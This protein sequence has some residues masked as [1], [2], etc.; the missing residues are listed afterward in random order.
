[1]PKLT[2]YDR[3]FKTLNL[4]E[5]DTVPTFEINIH[6]V[7]R[8]AILSGASYE[9]FIEFMDLDAAVYYEWSYDKYETLN[10]VKKIVRDKFGVVKRYTTEI[11]PIPIESAIKSEED[12]DKYIAPDPD[13]PWKYEPLQKA[14]QR[15]KDQ[16]PVIATVMDVFYQ[17]NEIRGM[18]DHFM[19]IIRKPDLIERLN[20]IVLNYNLR[21]IRNC[22]EVGVDII[23]ITGDLATSTGPMVSP[24]HMQRFAIPA[25][26]SMVAE[27]KKHGVPCLR[28]THGNIWTIFDMI[29]D[30][31]IDA[32]HPI[33]PEAGM[34]I[35]EAKAKY[36]TRVCLIGNIK[37]GTTLSWGTEEEVRQEVKACI[38]K[39]GKGGGFVCAAASSVHSKVKP[40]NYIAM[41][42]AIR[43]YGKYPLSF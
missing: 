2:H 7:V 32:I 31:G 13:V 3:V 5:P 30:T 1:M 39:A 15:F 19:D 10:D 25:L 24:K 38:K 29:V 8:N 22:I 20:E 14:V 43:E 23:W 12:L 37:T 33:D 26:R 18:T 21:Y 42:K 41:V 35:G 11:D 16:K 28:H 9:D 27:C 17:V 6:P 36:G 34:D 40:Q 4:Q